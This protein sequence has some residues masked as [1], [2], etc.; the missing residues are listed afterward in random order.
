MCR[1]TQEPPAALLMVTSAAS[2]PRTPMTGYLAEPQLPS[3]RYKA[4]EAAQ[5]GGDEAH[6]VAG[7]RLLEALQPRPGVCVQHH[8][9]LLTEVGMLQGQLD[10]LQVGLQ[11]GA[12]VRGPHAQLGPVGDGRGAHPAA[13]LVDR[14][15]GGVDSTAHLSDS[16]HRQKGMLPQLHVGADRLTGVELHGRELY[17]GGSQTK[18]NTTEIP[19]RFSAWSLCE[20]EAGISRNFRVNL[21]ISA[22]H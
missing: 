13:V 5:D 7:Q 6:I 14:A 12:V 1:V 10:D 19:C 18:H 21:F 9:G 17:G 11:G 15:V 16:C 20:K 22:L 2:L 4:Q 8:C 3:L